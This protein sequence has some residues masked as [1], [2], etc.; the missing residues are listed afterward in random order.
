MS[1]LILKLTQWDS[2]KN[3]FGPNVYIPA[4]RITGI[5]EK[6]DRHAGVMRAVIHVLGSEQLPVAESVTYVWNE[7]SLA[8]SIFGAR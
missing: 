3:S 5:H 1:D 6:W 2:E 8:P 4:S 7:F